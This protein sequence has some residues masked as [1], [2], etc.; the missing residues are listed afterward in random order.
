[1]VR[2]FIAVLIMASTNAELS[3]I[4]KA[5]ER[6]DRGWKSGDA[7]MATADYA[8]D[9]ELILPNGRILQGRRTILEAQRQML[10]RRPPAKP[11]D[12]QEPPMND[13]IRFL[14]S[15]VAVV[16]RTF[17]AGERTGHSLRVFVK[18]NGRWQIANEEIMFADQ[19]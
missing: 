1:M 16:T 9:A 7:E 13:S 15:T 18:R 12:G 19:R 6:G 10:A 17:P 11:G 5:I 14:T 8:A 3:A 2:L 4:M